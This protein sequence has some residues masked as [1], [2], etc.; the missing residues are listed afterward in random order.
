MTL[1][2]LAGL[3]VA[4][5]LLLWAGHRLRRRSARMRGAFW[6]GLAGHSLGLMV[7]LAA[8]HYPPVHWD[9]A[10]LRTAAIH[11][12]MLLGAVLGAAVGAMLRWRGGGVRAGVGSGD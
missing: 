9:G 1:A 7:T 11:A 10:P 3:L 6:G 12:S 5:A 8:V 4:P 2:L